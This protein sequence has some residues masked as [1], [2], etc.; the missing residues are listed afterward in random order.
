LALEALYAALADSPVQPPDPR[1]YPTTVAA[2]TT[3]KAFEA[4]LEARGIVAANE[5]E[6]VKDEADRARKMAGNIRSQHSRIR[7]ELR[8]R[9]LFAEYNGTCWC[10][11]LKKDQ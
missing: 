6:E 2:F 7:K 4:E 8:E 3:T 5:P 10:P 9:Q 11:E 1:R